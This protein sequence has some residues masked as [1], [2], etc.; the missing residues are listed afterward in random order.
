[1][2]K[3]IDVSKHQG[4]I[5]WELVKPNIDFAI[6]RCGYGSDYTKQDDQQFERNVAECERL[7][8]PYAVYLYSYADTYDKV[9]SEVQHTLRLIKGKT[10]FCVYYDMEDAST[11]TLGKNILTDYA[12]RYC[13][14]IKK[15]GY[16]VGVYAN[17]NWFKN[18]LDVKVLY[19]LGY[20]I[21]VAKYSKFKPKIAITEGQ[22][23]IWQYSSKG[24]MEGIGSSGLDMNYMYNDIRSFVPVSKDSVVET[25]PV[26]APV[27]PVEKP[28]TPPPTV[29]SDTKYT[30]GQK[31]VLKNVKLYAAASSKNAVAVKTG[32]YYL[33]NSEVV[34]GKI[35]ITNL[36]TNVGRAGQVTGWIEIGDVSGTQA[37]TQ[38]SPQPSK[39]VTNGGVTTG[40]L[41]QLSKAPLYASSTTTK[42]ASRKTG[43]YYIW[44]NYVA[45]GRVRITNSA[46][47]VGKSGQVTGWINVSDI[48]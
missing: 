17:E 23:D 13:E 10:P 32:T 4:I 15:E 1:M 21:W 12:K 47:N 36:T 27:T 24:K 9:D 19:S 25:P 48:K 28:T 20:S 45:N 11:A 5:G 42:V 26:V 7:N 30:A 41:I 39:P 43:K 16:K 6:L 35:R 44:D 46:S 2:L 37:A 34:N 14:A 29:S 40:K 38:T 8:I 3:G 33:W 31:V 18:Y 22:Y